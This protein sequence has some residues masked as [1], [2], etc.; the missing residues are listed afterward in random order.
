[1][2]SLSLSSKR[3][4]GRVGAG[5]ETDAVSVVGMTG[6]IPFLHLICVAR[7]AAF[8][9]IKS[10]CSHVYFFTTSSTVEIS[11]SL[12]LPSFFVTIFVTPNFPRA[13]CFDFFCC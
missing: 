9:K 4:A 2:F 3:T 8:P 1:M 12:A 11:Q 13:V 6:T 7:V 10:E 5:T